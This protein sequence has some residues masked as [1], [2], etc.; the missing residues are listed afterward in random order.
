MDIILPIL[1]GW[2]RL[3][4][5]MCFTKLYGRTLIPRI[6]DAAFFDQFENLRQSNPREFLVYATPYTQMSGEPDLDLHCPFL[7]FR[8]HIPI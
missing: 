7:P 8:Q 5:R 4:Y 1:L 6:F 2:D 3:K